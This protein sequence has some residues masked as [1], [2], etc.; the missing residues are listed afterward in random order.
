MILGKFHQASCSWG[1]LP[2]LSPRTIVRA[3]GLEQ[4][5]LTPYLPNS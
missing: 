1:L 4:N 5:A 3:Q 2:N